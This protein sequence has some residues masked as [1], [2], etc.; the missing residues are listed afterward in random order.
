[1]PNIRLFKDI[2][3]KICLFYTLQYKELA[4]IIKVMLKDSWGIET[5]Q[6]KSILG[7]TKFPKIELPILIIADGDFHT[8]NV[9][10]QTYNNSIYLYNPIS[11][12]LLKNDSLK[13]HYSKSTQA[14]ASKFLYSNRIGIIVST[15]YGQNHIEKAESLE[16]KIKKTGKETAIFLS[17]TINTAEFENF[18]VDFW[19]NTACPRLAED[20]PKMINSDDILLY[21]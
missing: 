8:L 10:F 5:D 13:E 3:K 11:M 2:P 7:C 9:L 14:K 19:V 16:K 15:K 18:N 6:F 20:S 21:L 12:Q 1:M 17:N 4:E